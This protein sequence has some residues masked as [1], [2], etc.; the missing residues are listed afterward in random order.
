ME[1]LWFKVKRRDLAKKDN[2]DNSTKSFSKL[3]L[4]EVR[5]DIHKHP[6]E[7][8]AG[9]NRCAWLVSKKHFVNEDGTSR[10]DFGSCNNPTKS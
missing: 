6:V 5:P 7:P 10:M 3:G 4:Q 2:L 1:K 8:F 9:L